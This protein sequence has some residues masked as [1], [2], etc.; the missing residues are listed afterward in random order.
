MIRRLEGS[1]HKEAIIKP[2]ISQKLADHTSIKGSIGVASAEMGSEY[3][4]WFRQEAAA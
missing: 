3:F 2:A 4:A 1:S